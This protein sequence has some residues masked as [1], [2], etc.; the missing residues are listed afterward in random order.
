DD[1]TLPCHLS[2]KRSAVAMDIRWFKG[3]DC[4]CEYQNGQVREGKDYE[5]RVSLFTH[6]LK[7]GN[8]SLMLRNVQELDNGVYKCKVTHGKD[9]VESDQNSLCVKVTVHAYADDEV[10]LPCY[11]SPPISAV[12]MEIRWFKGTDCICVYQNGQVN[13][14]NG[15][16]GKV[17]LFNHKLEKGNV[18]L[19]LRNVQESDDGEYKCEVTCQKCKMES[20]GV[21]LHVSEFKL[22][23][24]YSDLDMPDKFYGDDVTLSCHLFPQ[25]SA[26]AM[27]IRWFKEAECICVCQN[28]QVNEGNGYESRVSLYTKELE[29]GNVSLLLRNVQ[30]SDD[31]KYTCE[32]TQRKDKV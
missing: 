21:S 2:P 28:G 18:S 8:L 20:N 10:T 13:E 7:E 14:G 24:S 9:K 27:E 1:A 23:S 17:C 32:V 6:E 3:A 22:V 29:D 31:G 11:L 5:G 4:I 15:F 12:P 30:E 26:V 25:M 16:Q 19:M